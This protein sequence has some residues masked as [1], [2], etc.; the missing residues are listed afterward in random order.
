MSLAFH[1]LL[2]A[3]RPPCSRRVAFFFVSAIRFV[4]F[5]RRS[6][7]S[8]YDAPFGGLRD[9]GPG[10]GRLSLCLFLSG[11]PTSSEAEIGNLTW[12]HRID[13]PMR[14]PPRIPY[15][16]RSSFV[17]VQGLVRRHISGKLA[18]LFMMDVTSNTFG[19]WPFS[20]RMPAR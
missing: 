14:I 12:S 6:I 3:D 7:V 18:Q 9:L 13:L 4:L 15:V 2:Y 1:C 5:V 19:Q 16:S 20:D 8:R 17:T 11:G 10:P